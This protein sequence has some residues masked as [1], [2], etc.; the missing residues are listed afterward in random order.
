MQSP[1]SR[2]TVSDACPPG[3]AAR[4][5][6]RHGSTVQLSASAG[7]PARM[8]RHMRTPR[9]RFHR[10]PMCSLDGS[11]CGGSPR[12]F[13]EKTTPDTSFGKSGVAVQGLSF[14]ARPTGPA[15]GTAMRPRLRPRAGVAPALLSNTWSCS[16]GLMVD[17]HRDAVADLV[18]ESR[19]DLPGALIRVRPT[20]ECRSSVPYE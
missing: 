20:A 4:L 6:D 11:P 5:D 16:T 10:S 7:S 1:F 13:A 2:R 14:A 12:S 19:T 3:R 9:M 15:P 17:G 8:I 18:A